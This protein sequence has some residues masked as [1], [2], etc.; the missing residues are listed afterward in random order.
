[1]TS[2]ARQ[3]GPAFSAT[4]AEITETTDA[5]ESVATPYAIEVGDSFLGTLAT[6]GDRD[7]IAVELQAGTSYTVSLSGVSS[8]G[9]SLVDPYL[10]LLDATGSVVAEDDDGGR[11]YDS[12]L[13]FTA[14]VT[15]TYYIEAAAYADDYAGT[16]TA[17]LNQVV[18]ETTDAPEN[19]GTPYTIGVGDSFEGTL[20]TAGDRDW[21][22]IEL[23]EGQL[24]TFSMQGAPSGV[25]TLDDPYLYL[26]DASGDL[27]A[28]NDDGGTGYDSLLGYIA[29]TSGTY[30][31]EAAAYGDGYAGSYLIQS[32][33][34]EP[35]EPGTLDELATYL[36]DG[37]WIDNGETPRAFDTASGNQITV[38][39]TSLGAAGQQLARWAFEAWEMVADL[40]FVE[41]TGGSADITF[42]DSDWGAY[43]DSIVSG[44]EI[45]SSTVNVSTDWLS[46][47]GTTID[48]YSFLTYVHEI[49]HALGLGHQGN[50]N[51]DASYGVDETFSN[52]SW[53]LS[54]MSYFS[55]DDNTSVEAS[56]AY[57]AGAMMADILAIQ[58]LYG[59]PD[60]ASQTAGN[61]VWGEG[62]TLG[63]YLGAVMDVLFDGGSA[64]DLYGD[65]L[66]FT[67]YDRNGHDLVDLSS[68]D[69]DQRIDLR[70]ESLSDIEGGIGNLA[71]ARGTVIE[72]LFT[73]A[74]DDT[75]TGNAATNRIEAGAG[76]DMIDGG[77]ASDFLDGGTGND[78]LYGGQGNDSLLGRDGDDWVDGGD[79]HDNIALHGGDDYALGREGNDSIGGGDGNDTLYGNTGNDVIGGGT[80]DDYVNAGADQDAASGG[81][82][83]DTVLGGVGDDTLAGSYGNDSVDGGVGN[84][85][86]GGGTG[87]DTLTGGDGNDSIGAGDDDDVLAGEAGHDFLAGGA[88]DDTI[89]GGTGSDTLNGGSGSD[90][91]QGG[92]GADLFVFNDLGAG[93][94][95]V[96]EDF[97]NGT[98]LIRISGAAPADL[99]FETV[100]GGVAIG[101]DGFTILVEGVTTAELTT[102]DIIFV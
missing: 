56:F 83:A 37:Y 43:S 39:I 99:S 90:L 14:S 35:A 36:S 71:I 91:L 54:V 24:Y 93:E 17:S 80:G 11:N 92:G 20:D 77:D 97:E 31:I 47:Y 66:A 4:L 52:D 79:N 73:G 40:E 25:G 89:G 67:L 23:T 68:S 81:Y 45:I 21:I 10:S 49:G 48:S 27:V 69:A 16:Y 46:A 19:A 13:T 55:Q 34:S 26:Y 60:A 12:A 44:G 74:G 33:E 41:V 98:D 15:G 57:L 8:G 18:V 62:S 78:T 61:T 32:A 102:G 72:D 85:N 7:W 100:S 1:M 29:E 87:R 82:G 65:P 50:Y 76:H 101:I 58:S 42:D 30:Y 96:I 84:D 2:L 70:E 3:P 9:G 94:T 6:T 28:Q 5:P 75:L 22:A 88:G 51:G 63:G 38:D 95:D 59:A 53:Q 64:L 86:M